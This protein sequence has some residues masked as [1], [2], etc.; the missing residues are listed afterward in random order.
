M[1]RD[2]DL[3]K[4]GRIDR[5]GMLAAMRRLDI[6]VDPR[7]VDAL[8]AR[9]GDPAAGMTLNDFRDHLWV[10]DRMDAVIDERRNARAGSKG[11]Q[12][13]AKYLWTAARPGGSGGGGRPA[14]A[15]GTLN[16]TLEAD[17][18][19]A[20]VLPPRLD[21]NMSSVRYDIVSF[22]GRG[23]AAERPDA[24]LAVPVRRRPSLFS[25]PPPAGRRVAFDH[26]DTPYNVV[27]LRTPR[28]E[29]LPPPPFQAS[30]PP[31]P[32]LMER[33]GALPPFFTC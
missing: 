32:L 17:R 12:S 1:F 11:D 23:R 21:F 25:P 29:H 30:D 9:C 8:M 19:A 7:V 16:D 31:A 26:G 22:D 18:R 27:T 13:G 6:P 14:A 5:D 4:R 28:P 3:A 24:R 10:D 20:G 33:G 2:T 15:V